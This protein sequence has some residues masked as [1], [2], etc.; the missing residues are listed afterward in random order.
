MEFLRH[1]LGLCGEAHPN[2]FTLLAGTPI[3]GYIIWWFKFV[4]LVEPS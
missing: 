3:L 1:A 4:Y 2:L